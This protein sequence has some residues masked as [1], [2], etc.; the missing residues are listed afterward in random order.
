M[1]IHFIY[2][3][4]DMKAKVREI[5]I[6]N[7]SDC[8]LGIQSTYGNQCVCEFSC[9]VMSG[10]LQPHGLLPIRL[11]CTWNFPGKSTRMGC[12]SYV[13]FSQPRD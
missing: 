3:Y 9:S 12:I 8:S 5:E 11:F 2:L 1:K 10:S 6:P 13:G 4:I 7:Q